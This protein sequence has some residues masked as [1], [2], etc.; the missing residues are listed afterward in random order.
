MLSEILWGLG[1]L[2]IGGC[3][4]FQLARSRPGRDEWNAAA[5]PLLSALVAAEPV[6]ARGESLVLDSTQLAAFQQVATRGEY[7]KFTSGVEYLNQQL[8]SAR[9]AHHDREQRQY[10]VDSARVSLANLQDRLKRR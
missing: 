4:G 9:A 8:E 10:L 2:V 7:F 5:S 6:V 3:I 1:G